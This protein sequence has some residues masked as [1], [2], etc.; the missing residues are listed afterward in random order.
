MS[1]PT[2]LALALA[3]SAVVAAGATPLAIAVA[4]RTSFYDRPRGYRAHE[5]PTPFLGGAAVIGAFLVA[6]LALGAFADG[7]GILLACTVAMWLIG[8]VDDRVTIPPRWRVVSEIGAA[9]AL[10]KA[11]LHWNTGLPH[12]ADFALTVLWVVGI[13]NAF[14]LMDNLDGACGTVA[15]VSASGIAVLAALQHEPVLSG[16]AVALAAACTTFL[17]WNLARPAKVF[18]G[19]GGSMPIGPVLAG[20]AMAVMRPLHLSGTSVAVGAL[21]LGLPI[22]DV[23]LVIVSRARRRVAFLTG[24][25]DHLTHRLSL[26]VGSPRSVAVRLGLAQGILCCLGI[27]GAELGIATLAAVSALAG[28]VG[29]WAVVVF[30][31]PRWRPPNIAVGADMPAARRST[32]VGAHKPADRRSSVPSTAPQSTTPYVAGS[33]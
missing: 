3:V 12:V 6:A 27:L 33:R 9:A 2:S 26:T 8:T 31:R 30:D 22:I 19:D 29:L 7:F 18:L 25:R 28:F 10:Y 20:L 16:M 13:V 24:G 14:N 17:R 32:T 21:L 4:R 11:G 15:S 1:L 23:T 5:F